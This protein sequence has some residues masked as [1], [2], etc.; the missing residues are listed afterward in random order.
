MLSNRLAFTIEFTDDNNSFE[1][2]QLDSPEDE[3]RFDDK[4]DL[5][6][7]LGQVYLK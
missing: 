4:Y 6:E 1:D 2:I 7:T 3:V 5:L